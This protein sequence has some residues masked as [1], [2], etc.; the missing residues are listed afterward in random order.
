MRVETDHAGEGD[1]AVAGVGAVRPCEGE[2]I[3]CVIVYLSPQNC[4]NPG[5]DDNSGAGGTLV[6]ELG[7]VVAL[8]KRQVVGGN[9]C[10]SGI[11]IS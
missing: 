9:A 8:P 6:D 1:L 3:E 11:H 4:D 7:V 2:I 10:Q 5:L